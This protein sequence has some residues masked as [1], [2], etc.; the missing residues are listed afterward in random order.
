MHKT[1]AA[2]FQ[3]WPRPDLS[4]LI[5]D[6]RWGHSISLETL[7][8]PALIFLRLAAPDYGFVSVG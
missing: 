3:K 1:V 7:K 2:V 5:N 8:A 4:G 6:E